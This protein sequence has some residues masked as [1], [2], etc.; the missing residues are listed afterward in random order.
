[1]ATPEEEGYRLAQTIHQERMEQLEDLKDH[2]LTNGKLP[3][4]FIIVDNWEE[5][6]KSFD[7][8]SPI[9]Y[10]CWALPKL[11][12]NLLAEEGGGGE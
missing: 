11:A 10:R 9:P 7:N 4:E 12:A 6:L 3:H 8:K 5:V 2:M 1:M